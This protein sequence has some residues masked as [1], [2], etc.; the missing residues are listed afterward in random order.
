VHNSYTATSCAAY[1]A[2]PAAATTPATRGNERVTKVLRAC[3]RMHACTQRLRDALGREIVTTRVDR[4][5]RCQCDT[6][7]SFITCLIND[8]KDLAERN[9][10]AM[11]LLVIAVCS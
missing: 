2:P 9:Y 10:V 6:V 8:T 3:V 4:Y 1:V 5:V 11:H 7:I